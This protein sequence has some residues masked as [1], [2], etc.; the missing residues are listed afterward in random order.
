MVIRIRHATTEHMVSHFMRD[1]S[2]FRCMKYPMINAA[3]I[4]DNP[5]RMVSIFTGCMR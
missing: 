1:T 4:S 5:I 2:Y 3:F